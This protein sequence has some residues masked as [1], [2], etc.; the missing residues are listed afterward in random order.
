M[1]EPTSG[2]LVM[3]M[4]SKEGGRAVARTLRTEASV[5]FSVVLALC[6][7]SSPEAVTLRLNKA[8]MIK[9]SN[10]MLAS[11]NKRV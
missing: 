1:M 4:A 9:V 6:L 11:T 5:G 7:F 2:A 8:G 3:P 10:F